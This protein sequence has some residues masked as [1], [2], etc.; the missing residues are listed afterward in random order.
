MLTRIDTDRRMTLRQVVHRHEQ[1]RIR[2]VFHI[3]ALSHS[4][5]HL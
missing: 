1:E 2:A 4:S 5:H 3:T